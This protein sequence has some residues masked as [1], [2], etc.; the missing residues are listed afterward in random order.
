MTDRLNTK[1]A[2]RI[3]SEYGV[4][5]DA[6]DPEEQAAVVAAAA[7]IRDAAGIDAAEWAAIVRARNLA[8]GQ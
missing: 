4:R 5:F 1:I 2:K 3:A 7:V 6:L 8:W